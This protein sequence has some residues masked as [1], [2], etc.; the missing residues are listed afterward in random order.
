[1]R[2][3]LI[4]IRSKSTSIFPTIVIISAIISLI[5]GIILDIFIPYNFWYNMIRAI[6]A[7]VGAFGI[8]SFSYISI[9]T[10]RKAN[11]IET[12][13]LREQFSQKQRINLSL[14]GGAI[15]LLG[16]ILLVKPGKPIFTLYSSIMILYLITVIAFIR[17]TRDEYLRA[18]AG[19]DDERD[20]KIKKDVVNSVKEED[21]DVED[22]EITKLG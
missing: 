9:T 14:I 21:L 2:E 16:Y 3:L 15:L 22:S 11:K 20:I 6:L 1:M 4:W 17:Y 10:Y 19:V 8:F 7:S 5:T 18:S 12:L 13:T